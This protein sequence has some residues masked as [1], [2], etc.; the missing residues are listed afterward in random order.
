M[1]KIELGIFQSCINRALSLDARSN[2]RLK[3]LQGKR[4]EIR[5]L[6][7]KNRPIHNSVLK[8]LQFFSGSNEK[9]HIIFQEQGIQFTEFDNFDVLVYGPLNSFITLALTK[10]ALTAAQQGLTFEG[11]LS[12]VEAIKTLFLSLEIDW[13]EY[14]SRFTGDTI[15]HQISQLCHTGFE[16]QKEFL[17]NTRVN[18]VLYLTEEAKLIPTQSELTDFM[19]KVDILSADVERLQMRIDFILQGQHS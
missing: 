1:I 10:N 4:L 17:H 19:E 14:L 2:E 8:L 16:R 7:I 15:A 5:F 3:K 11:D 12:L 18:S 6:P 9:F 13:E